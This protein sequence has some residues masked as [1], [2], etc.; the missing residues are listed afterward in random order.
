MDQEDR[1]QRNHK[2]LESRQRVTEVST[3]VSLGTIT[4]G[5][6]LS[7]NDNR[8]SKKFEQ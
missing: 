7:S 6:V 8:V 5:K 4:E 2:S 1:K 3:K